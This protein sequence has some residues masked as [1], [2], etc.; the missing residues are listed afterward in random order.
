MSVRTLSVPYSHL[1]FLFRPACL[2]HLVPTLLSLLC[3]L[4]G[5]VCVYICDMCACMFVLACARANPLDPVLSPL[6]LPHE[7]VC[8][9]VEGEG[10]WCLFL[11]SG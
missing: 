5:G 4:Q 11:Y 7:T 1:V 3:C 8:V 10:E 2:K 6:K 9:C